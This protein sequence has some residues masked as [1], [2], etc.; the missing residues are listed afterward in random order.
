MATNARKVTGGV[1]THGE[2]HHA[3][4][5]DEVGRQL[6]DREFP[7]TPRGY[8]ALLIWLASFG[9][10]VRVGV[11]G[12]GAYGAALTRYLRSEGVQVVEVDRPDRQTRRAKGKS[13][14]IDAY[15]AALAALSGRAA[16]TPKS[17]DGRIEAPRS[18]ANSSAA[19]PLE[20]SSIPASGCAPLVISLTPYKP[21][22]PRCA[23]WPTVTSG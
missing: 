8:R 9:T 13:D 17:R 14:P 2:T 21:P 18:C 19:C 5:V 10:L 11:E 6:A 7:T 15:A 22:R 1:D 16:G 3:A 23:G 12:T 20:R 4:V